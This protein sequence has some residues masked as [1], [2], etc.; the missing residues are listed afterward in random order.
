[1]SRAGIVGLGLWVP[2]EVREND[3]WPASFV[4]AFHEKTEARRARDFT[5]ID[6]Q[7]TGRPYDELYAKHALLYE[8]DPFKGATRRRV[9][10]PDVPTAQGDSVAATRAL[11]DARVDPRDVD[12]VL[13]SAI[14]PDR[15]VPSNGPAIQHLTGCTRAAGIGV[16]AYC[17]SAL[18]QLDLAAGLVEAGRARL[19]LCVQSHQIGRIND[20]ESP[21]SPIFGDGSAAFVVGEVPPDRGLVRLLRAGDGSLAGAVTHDYARTPGA[22]WWRDAEGPVRPGSADLAAAR[23]IAENVIA[24]A[25]DT[26]RD[27]CRA[28]STPIDAVAAIAALQPM[29]WYQGAIADGLGIPAER[30]PSTYAEYAHLGAAGVVANLIAARRRGILQGGA[31]TVLYAH[32]AGLTRYAALLR[33]SAGD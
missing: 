3:A 7:R 18:A 12:L 27:L 4:R 14:V 25:I 8:D 1:M 22:A 30:V 11:E 21:W 28:A 2:D 15:L 5:N 20:L 23:Y 6:R 10:S 29:V 31:A 32:G 26:I 16:E 19:V 24:F 9:A 13:S 17:S 33:W